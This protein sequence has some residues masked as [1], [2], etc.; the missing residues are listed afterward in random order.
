MKSNPPQKRREA[1]SRGLLSQ[2]GVMN[3]GI[4]GGSACSL[5]H[6]AA[7]FIARYSLCLALQQHYGVMFLSFLQHTLVIIYSTSESFQI[8]TLAM[9]SA[10]SHLTT[11]YPHLHRMLRAFPG[12]K[13]LVNLPLNKPPPPTTPVILPPTSMITSQIILPPVNPQSPLPINPSPIP[14]PHP[15]PPPKV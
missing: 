7:C 11:N 12:K 2:Y 1:R 5:A 13:P 14:T 8:G 9:F 3:G 10:N 15:L 6:W 4:K